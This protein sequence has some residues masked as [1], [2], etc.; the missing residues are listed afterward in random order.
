MTLPK[1]TA[2][3]FDWDDTIVES[4]PVA[5]ESLNAALTGMGQAAWSD[6]EAR[7]RCGG[8]ARDMF[9]TL[10]GERWQEADKIYY[11]TYGRL[12]IENV[13]IHAHAEDI[14]KALAKD[15]VYLAVVSNKRGT[16]LR[17][18]AARIQFDKYFGKIIGAGD[19]EA[20]KPHPAV[21]HMA[22]QDSGIAAGPH[23]W[24][25]GDSHTDMLCALNA[26]CTSILLETKTPPEETL[27]NNP[28]ARRFKKHHD[29]MEFIKTCFR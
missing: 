9:Q 13:R 29:L 16:L 8:S 17:L 3:I 18:E 10:F 5:L 7:R 28:P 6:D 12:T 27:L 21:V 1:P 24:F 25:V 23:V 15:K 22:L 14:L 19:A 11:D 26:G 2:V 20:D 4:W